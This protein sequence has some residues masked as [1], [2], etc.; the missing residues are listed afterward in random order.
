[1]TALEA[2]IVDLDGTLA[3]SERFGH[4]VAFNAAFEQLGLPDRWAQEEYGDLLRIPGGKERLSHH[5]AA[6]GM[7]PS[8]IDAYVPELH[9]RKNEAFLGL[10]SQGRIPARPGAARLL[11]EIDRAGLRLGLATTGSREWV[12]PL[13]DKL[14]GPGRFDVVVTGDEVP[15]KK[16]DPAAYEL[17][18]DRLGIDAAGAVAVEDSPQGLASAHGAGLPCVVV[19]N[20][21][22]RRYDYSDA[23]LVV[24]G[25]GERGAP[26]RLVHDPLEI[27]FGGV[28]TAE[29]V[30]SVHERAAGRA[31][32]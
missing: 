29:V 16:P 27:G 23:D 10:A 22:T 11:D 13:V 6:R 18:L 1:M 21:Y 31:R 17:A 9:T 30:A 26:A 2:V 25:F 3:D 12:V 19:V 5:L 28:V 8:E 7:A 32:T 15:A 24:D 14:F 20:D 4:R